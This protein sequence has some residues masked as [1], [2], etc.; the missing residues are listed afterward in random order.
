MTCRRKDFLEVG[1]FSESMNIL[2][3]MDLCYKLFYGQKQRNPRYTTVKY[4]ERP[5][6]RKIAIINKYVHTSGI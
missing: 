1:G 5:I 2:E 6:G 4:R 3:D